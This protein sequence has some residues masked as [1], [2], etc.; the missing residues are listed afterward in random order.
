MGHNLE[1]SGSHVYAD[2]CD[3]RKWKSI[4]RRYQPGIGG[5]QN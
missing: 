2:I 1:V 5:V 3:I 4:D